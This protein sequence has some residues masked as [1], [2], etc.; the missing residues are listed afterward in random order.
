MAVSVFLGVFIGLMP[1][2]GVALILTAVAAQLLRV[3]KGPGLLASF[4]AV[5]PTLFLFF[6]PLGYFAV[7]LPLVE[8]PPIDFDFLG[9]IK[10][11]NWSTLQVIGAHLWND[12][13]G[14]LIA[15]LVGMLIV[16]GGFAL[17]A[18]AGTY[19]MMEAKRRQRLERRRERREALFMAD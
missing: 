1:T 4:V 16:A 12:A 7:G 17:L 11:L 13:S 14:H 9:E 19:V 18:F 3:P 5:P 2:L 8:P 6:Y 10:R 15:F